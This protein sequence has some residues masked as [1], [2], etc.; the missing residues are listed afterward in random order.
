MSAL[1][2]QVRN[3]SVRGRVTAAAPLAPLHFSVTAAD[4]PEMLTWLTARLPGPGGEDCPPV[5]VDPPVPLVAVL[6]PPF[7]LVTAVPPPV[8]PPPTPEPPP[9]VSPPPPARSGF[10]CSDNGTTHA[11][12]DVEAALSQFPDATAGACPTPAESAAATP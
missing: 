1:L 10:I 7:A 12:Q 2:A 4:V 9:P 6:P 3:A 8:V 11:V 5:P